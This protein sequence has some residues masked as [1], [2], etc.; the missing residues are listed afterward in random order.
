[1]RNKTVVQ[2]LRPVAPG[3]HVLRRRK[4]AAYVDEN[5]AGVATGCNNNID[6]PN[7]C[8]VIELA[9]VIGNFIY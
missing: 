6:V 3:K 9:D 4:R 8:E 5:A 1:L 2:Q 7:H